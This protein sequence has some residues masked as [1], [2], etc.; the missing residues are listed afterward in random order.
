[1]KRTEVT[2]GQ[3]DKVLRFLGF[4]CRLDTTPQRPA[5]VYEH[6][7]SGALIMFP[8]FP[9]SDKVL[10]YHLIQTRVMLDEFGIADP[11]TFAAKLQKAC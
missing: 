11:I 4:S 9:E 8:P 3:V 5:R 1:M 6:K 2:Y 10:E 7:K